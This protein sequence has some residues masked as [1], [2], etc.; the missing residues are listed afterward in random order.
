M[1]RVDHDLY[2]EQDD[3]VTRLMLHADGDP[4]VCLI[5]YE[6]SFVELAGSVAVV[7]IGGQPVT[8]AANHF[9]IQ[10]TF[11]KARGA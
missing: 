6:R 11:A 2:A 8:P 1:R 3:K 9:G 4:P 5:E 7:K 10:I